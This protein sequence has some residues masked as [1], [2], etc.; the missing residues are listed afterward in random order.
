MYAQMGYSK[1]M[2]WSKKQKPENTKN[3]ETKKVTV[4]VEHNERE[5]DNISFD[6]YQPGGEERYDEGE[7]VGVV[8]EG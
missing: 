4:V 6:G 2:C 1:P 3:T 7:S 8:K 5:V